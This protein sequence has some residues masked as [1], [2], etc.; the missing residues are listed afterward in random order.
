MNTVFLCANARSILPLLRAASE[1]HKLPKPVK[2]RM[3]HILAKMEKRTVSN[4][5]ED[6]DEEGIKSSSL[7]PWL[8]QTS[9]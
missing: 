8:A 2:C 1:S 7:A 3:G 4:D 9:R 6:E 5:Q